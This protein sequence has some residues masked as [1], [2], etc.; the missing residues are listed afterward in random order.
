MH[1]GRG[2]DT[3]DY[4]AFDVDLSISLHN[5][6]AHGLEI[7]TDTI[8]FIDNIVSGAGD[9]TLKG[10]KGVNEIE[11]GAGDDTIRS[12][13]G[14]DTLTGGD[15]SD[16]FVFRT[17]DLDA[18]DIIT[19]FEIGLDLLDFSHLA[20]NTDDETFLARIQSS[21]AG[22]DLMLSADLSGGGAY[23]DVCMLNN[24]GNETVTTLFENDC[25]IF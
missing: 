23:Q 2:N 10:S 19:D 4:S 8:R 1:G 25:F 17:Y 15:G 20:G 3:V 22:D 13:Q 24:A 11:A 16:T 14:A 9:D 21:S 6:R 5:N 18:A 12:L 7:G